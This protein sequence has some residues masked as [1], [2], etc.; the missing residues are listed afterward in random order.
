MCFSY[1]HKSVLL[2]GVKGAGTHIQEGTQF[3]NEPVKR[4]LIL[5]I[6]GPI[7]L[8]DNAAQVPA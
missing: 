6:F 8:A 5:Q 2:H 7:S 3:L 4:G 1:A